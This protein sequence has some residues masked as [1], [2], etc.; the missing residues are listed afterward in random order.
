MSMKSHFSVLGV[1]VRVE[2]PFF[3]LVLIFGY[4]LYLGPEHPHGITLFAL[5]IPLVTGA[6]LLHELGHALVARAYGLTP[7]VVLHGFGGLTAYDAHAHRALSH[8]R[9]ILITLAGPFAGIALGLTAL[10]VRVTVFFPPDSVAAGALDGVLLTTLG[11][12]I[13]NLFPMLPLD[14]GHVVATVLD[15]LFGRRGVSFARLASIALALVLAALLATAQGLTPNL[16]ILGALA[17]MNWRAYREERRWQSDAPFEEPLR[18]ATAALEQGDTERAI[19][20]AAA[21]RERAPTP[22]VAARSAHVLAWACL[23][24]ED[25]EGARRALESFPTGHPPDAFLEGSVLLATGRAG[26]ALGPLVEA[27][28]GRD[29]EDVPEALA[30]AIAEAGRLDEMVGLLESRER[31]ERAGAA[32]VQRVAHRLFTEGHLAL[33]GGLYERLFARFGEGLDAFNAAC[34]RARLGETARALRLLEQALDAGLE[35]PSVLD[36]DADL[37]SLRG[38]PELERL[39]SRL[40]A[41]RSG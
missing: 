27:L 21:I 31:S 33:A 25:V 16:L 28:V 17:Y 23:V 9:R 4:L 1:P 5:W 35:D 38:H 36:T 22:A 39:R 14:G 24:R 3:F 13:L 32:R 19:Q 20:L 18:H 30:A 12:G 2:P 8:G 10:A 40:D 37:A 34:A 26:A 15:K 29:E 41:D 7:F 6:V 11:W